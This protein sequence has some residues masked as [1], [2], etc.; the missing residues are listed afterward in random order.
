MNS[1]H[2]VEN[3]HLIAIDE[4]WTALTTFRRWL[5]ASGGVSYDPYDLLGTRYG[6]WARRL[7]YDKHP[8]GALMNAPL[9]LVELIAPWL[10]SLLVDKDR[11]A[12]A[13]AQLALGLMNL[14]QI[15][16]AAPK[17][18]APGNGN[19]H[20]WLTE[21]K[22]LANGL[23]KQS[24]P[25]YSGYCWGYP[26]HWQSVNGLISKNTP[27][28]TA[29]PYC[30]EAF[31]RLSD[32]TGDPQYLEVG[33]SIAAFVNNDLNDTP[34]GPDAAAASYTPNDHTK[35]VNASAYRAFVLFDA[36]RRLS[37]DAYHAKAWKNLRFILQTQKADGSWLYAIDNPP[38]AFIDHF[39]TCFVLKNLYKINR[40]LQS[41]DVRNALHN[42]YHY[43][44]EALFDEHTSPRSFAV[45]PRV[46]IVR[47]EMYNMAE[48]I[49]LGSLLK[50]E[51]PEAFEL[52][53]TLAARLI[54][55]YQ[56]PAGHWVTRI[57]VGGIRHTTPFMRWP[58][59]QL[60]YALTSLALA[61]QARRSAN[62]N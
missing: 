32:L 39:H 12:T 45:A 44:R 16:H 6:R 34:T 40:H 47:L 50:D 38:E 35:V 22:E 48:A 9:I 54:C 61:L 23:L 52:A 28:I 62:N 20:S 55:D 26:F 27:H 10:R 14:H 58:Q 24:V 33:R 41:D 8:L 57:Y 56:L 36:A 5:A 46:Q 2:A 4:L 1:A 7:Y 51:I 25:G 29:T 59:S 43:Y 49:N 13:D 11:F 53:Q 18:L 37:N 19:E 42:G 17:Y 15:S 60:F 3:R 31:T 30:Y 21:A